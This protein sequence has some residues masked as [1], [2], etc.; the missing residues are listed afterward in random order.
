MEADHSRDAVTKDS[1]TEIDLNGTFFSNI[2]D[3]KTST[4]PQNNRKMFKN[5][6]FPRFIDNDDKLNLP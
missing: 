5:T 2:D 6:P 3:Y 4:E 1:S